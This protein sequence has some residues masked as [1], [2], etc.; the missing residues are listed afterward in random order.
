MLHQKPAH[1][2]SGYGNEVVP[3]LPSNP[4][5]P[6]QPQVG[7]VHKGGGLKCLARAFA[8]H[9]V[10]RNSVYTR[11]NKREAVSS[12]FSSKFSSKPFVADGMRELPSPTEKKIS[13]LQRA[14]LHL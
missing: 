6:Y 7:F 3:V 12:P 14:V 1:R 8:A 5:L 10:R 13:K 9:I 11:G 2:N 4:F